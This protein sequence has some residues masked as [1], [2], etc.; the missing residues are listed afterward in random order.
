MRTLS[1][2]LAAGTPLAGL[3]AEERIHDLPGLT[4]TALEKTVS[5]PGLSVARFEAPATAEGGGHLREAL[6]RIPG[7]LVQ[8]SFG[9]I[10]PPRLSVR[11]SGIQSA[12]VSRGIELSLN[13]FPLSFADGSFNL[14]LVEAG[15]LDSAV[16]AGGP[17]GGV[18]ALGGSLSLWTAAG[19]GTE[20]GSARIVYGS[21][22]TVALLVRQ[23]AQGESESLGA[24]ASWTHTDGWRERS[25]QRRETALAV[26]RKGLGE[27]SEATVQLFVSR[28]RFDVPGPLPKSAAL[29]DPRANFARVV[30]DKPRRETDYAQLAARVTTDLPSGYLSAGVSASYHEDSFFQ[31]LPNGIT[32][33]RGREAAVFADAR[34]EWAGSPRQETDVSLRARTGSTD[35]DRYATDGGRRGVLI[36]ANRLRPTT[37]T[38]T[39]D[40]RVFVADYHSVEAGVSL[41]AARRRIGERF[42]RAEST[43]QNLSGT[44]AAPRV[45]W[46]YSPQDDLTFGL[47]WS[48]GYEPPTFDDLL[49][50][51]FDPP[52]PVPELRSTAL[53]WQRADS[54]EL[55]ARG[56]H[57]EFVWT[58]AVHFASWRREFLRLRDEF[59]AA[60]GTVNADRTVHAGWEA[61]ANRLINEAAGISW[62]GWA[63]WQFNEV[64]FDDDPVY[65]RNR[66]GGVPRH[67]GAAGL[68]G[69]SSGGWFVAPGLFWQAGKNFADHANTLSAGGFA[70][71]SLEAGRKHPSGWEAA[72]RVT[73]LFD[74]RYIAGTAGVLDEAAGPAQPI[75]LPDNGRRVEARLAYSW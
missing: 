26:A 75:F 72:V 29:E 18:P 8:E 45:A 41:L 42:D 44:K 39:M 71:G 74:R 54:L 43:A 7:L 11:G 1:F 9:G 61:S 6:Q 58:A 32:D 37:A 63:T 70:V 28:P 47:S 50:T 49:F 46:V 66:L 2:A 55:T 36:G 38:A 3:T 21:N 51:V 33:T 10:D 24:E 23:A 48:C 14:A 31:L 25:A 59:G 62:Y 73:N 67:A 20:G 15:W 13:G 4:V 19:L 16:L 40:H 5:G 68:R 52:P 69:E 12:P 17:A 56:T 30:Q 65:G 27:G 57:G 35:A 53:R 34:H 64:R 22:R 60:R